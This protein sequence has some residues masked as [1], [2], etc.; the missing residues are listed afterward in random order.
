VAED[1]TVPGADRPADPVVPVVGPDRRERARLTSYRFRF[2]FV[3]VLLAAVM[4]GAVGSFIVLVGRPAPAADESWSSWRPDGRENAYPT[5]IADHVAARYR[6][7]SG[8]QLVGVLAGPAEV[9]ELPIRAVL[10]QHE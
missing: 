2:G 5:A 10:I 8:K 4:G 9:Q 3:Y 1:V 6:L 7:P